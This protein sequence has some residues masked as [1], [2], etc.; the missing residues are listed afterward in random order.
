MGQHMG[1]THQN[2]RTQLKWLIRRCGEHIPFESWVSGIVWRR[3]RMMFYHVLEKN[4]F[5][6]PL[7]VI[8]VLDIS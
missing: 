2:S 1:H 7:P 6:T 5:T 4:A 3:S 8:K